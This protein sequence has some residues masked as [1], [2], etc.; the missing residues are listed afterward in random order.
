MVFFEGGEAQTLRVVGY[1][2]VS[3]VPDYFPPRSVTPAF[4]RKMVGV[5]K[6]EA[7]RGFRLQE[8]LACFESKSSGEDRRVFEFPPQTVE[9]SE[10]SKPTQAAG[11]RA[12]GLRSPRTRGTP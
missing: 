9:M 1:A 6:K 4:S 3:H 11:R 8:V 10:E 7:D 12:A 5:A 2:D